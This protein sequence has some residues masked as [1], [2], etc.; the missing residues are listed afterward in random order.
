[1][2][3]Q[4]NPVPLVEFVRKPDTRHDPDQNL[5][6]G[7]DGPAD[8]IPAFVSCHYIGDGQYDVIH[9]FE[10]PREL[11]ELQMIRRLRVESTEQDKHLRPFRHAYNCGSLELV[12]EFEK[13][14]GRVWAW[15]EPVEN[16]IMSREV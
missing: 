8:D 13:R 16:G 1:M 12:L 3:S 4:K 5:A 2:S 14:H 6:F 15:K 11:G 9:N 10:R 7:I